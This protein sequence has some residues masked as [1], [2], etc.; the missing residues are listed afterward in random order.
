VIRVVV[1]DDHAVVR[2]GLAQLLSGAGDIELVHAYADARELVDALAHDRPDVVLMDLAMPHLDG[3]EATRLVADVLPG[4]QVVVLTSF[5]DSDRIV[6]ALDAGAVGYLL[7][8][9]EPDQLL[10][11]I[12]AAA[13]GESPLAPKAARLLL[14]SRRRP[15]SE[16][17]LSERERDVL[18][19]VAT[20]LS[21]KVVAQRLGIAEKT[22]KAHLTNVYRV[23][24]VYDRV[25]AALWARERGWT[26]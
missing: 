1:A 10:D 12:R 4:A 9:T 3:I 15:A 8:D 2:S 5:S 24:G 16:P 7:K 19:L 17:E 11:G 22:V 26:R 21:N 25:Q 13:R 18:A 14:E 23:I 6:A 20:G